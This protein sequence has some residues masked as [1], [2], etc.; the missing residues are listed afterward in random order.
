METATAKVTRRQLLGA[1]AATSLGATSG[2]VQRLRSIANRQSSETVSLSVTAPPADSDRLATLIARHLVSNLEAAG[3][4][5]TLNILPQSELLREVL[6]N[7]NFDLFVT[8][9][10]PIVDPQEYTALLHSVFAGEQGWQNPYGVTD[11][12]TDD[13]LGA[14]Q[15]TAGDSRRRNARKL[16]RH[17]TRTQPFTTVGFPDEIRAVRTDQFTGWETGIA[18][19]ISY[20]AL[21]RASEIPPE[22]DLSLQLSITD[23]RLSQ[24]LNPLS[25]EYRQPE[26][27]T[28]LLYDPLVR[29]FG[30]TFVPWL[31]SEWAFEQDGQQSTITAS[32]RPGLIW[33][34][35]ISI[36]AQDVAF[37]FRFL[38][39][40][41]L[42]ELEQQ[43][44]A[45]FYRAWTSI[46][47][48]ARAIDDE[49]VRLTVET[50]SEAVARQVLL[51]PIFPA[52]IWRE[53]TSVADLSGFESSEN[54][55]EALVFANE[56]AIGSGPVAVGD[57]VADEEVVFQPFEE[58]FLTRG[59]GDL[60]EIPERFA[61]GFPFDELRF[62]V[63]PSNE[64]AVEL[65]VQGDLD[66]TAMDVDPREEIIERIA[67]ASEVSMVVERSPSAYHIGYNTST[68]PFSNPYFCRLVARLVD[69]QYIV[70][71][72]FRGYGAP[73][74]NPFDGTQWS[75][76]DLGF[77]SADPVV[78]FLGTDGEVDAEQ[79]RAEFRKQGFEF[80][81]DGT[82]LLR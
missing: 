56:D 78:P 9:L 30:E 32:L 38:S 33:H 8:R 18:S 41:S 44:P 13:Y 20:L 64:T 11:M 25:V 36:T 43:V 81:E 80:D 42:D 67:G 28:D 15:R 62:R 24:N 12:V 23:S 3:I 58:H 76:N 17:I 16:T 7:R 34:D 47:A 26:P 48:E 59:E 54:I 2:C 82:L 4:D 77:D 73:A 72:I 74:S 60:T 27:F 40:T 50:P 53:H 65:V 10:P 5:T 66:G 6:L 22:E 63:T 39:D 57:V 51:T 49:T 37:T 19:P 45:P 69:K 21:E 70:D 35:G 52:H 1:A 61:G 14:Q 31:A 68:R 71:N 75:P 55:T 79:A 29:R 46:V